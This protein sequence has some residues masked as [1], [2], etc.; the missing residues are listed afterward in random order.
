MRG[1]KIWTA[2]ASLAMVFASGA[3]QV[4]AEPSTTSENTID[5]AKTGSITLYKLKSS[6]GQSVDSTAQE[7]AVTEEGIPGV[8]FTYLKVGDIAQVDATVNGEVKSGVYYTMTADMSAFLTDNNIPFTADLTKDGTNYYTSETMNALMKNINLDAGGATALNEKVNAFVKGKGV[9]M[10]ATDAQG[11]TS[12]NSLALGLYM[13]AETDTSGATTTAANGQEEGIVKASRP[14]FVSLPMTNIAAIGDKAAGTVWQYDVVAYPKNEVASIHK[15]IVVDGN[16]VEDGADPNNGLAS[17]TNKN[18]GDYVTFLLTSDAPVLQKQ[19]NEAGSA[20]A[21]REYVIKDTMT[22][23][24]TLDDLTGTNF[25]VS[26]GTNKYNE[27]NKELAITTDYT[28]AYDTAANLITITFTP[29]G[30]GKL[31]ALTQDSKVFVKYAARLNEKAV[32]AAG[33]QGAVKVESNSAT[34]TFGTN[35]SASVTFK[36]NTDTKVYTYEMDL[37]KSFTGDA[38]GK[39]KSAVSFSVQAA[40]ADGSGN[41]DVVFVKEADG[42]YHVY[43]GKETGAQVKEIN[44]S[45]DGKL[46]VKGL[47]AR[48]YVLTEENTV[49]GYNLMRD[50][51][52]LKFDDNYLHDGKLD[53]ASVASGNAAPVAIT[54]GDLADGVVSFEILNNETITALHT[55][56]S[57]WNNAFVIMGMGALAAGLVMFASR[58]RRAA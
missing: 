40:K 54:N 20:N 46:I 9:A 21:Y 32:T 1:K 14:F 51:I 13:I 23:G 27:A 42:V 44:V 25:H 34:L 24:L 53:S 12:A 4:N 35:T 19:T 37:T 17:S 3:A 30:L 6:D 45:K 58:R 48:T 7:M 28:V 26:V 29:T 38:A 39:D 55:G 33:K 57:G 47:D 52:T 16:D 50:K 41:E 31:D 2:L 43:D 22:E 56:G 15:D 18:V 11:K 8:V 36:S 5:T 49:S 10:A